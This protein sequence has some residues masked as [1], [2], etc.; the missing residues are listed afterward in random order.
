MSIIK[1]FALPWKIV[2]HSTIKLHYTQL[3]EEV[4]KEEDNSTEIEKT[5]PINI[6]REGEL[7][8][9]GWKI[10]WTICSH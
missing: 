1:I 2:E 9:R 8:V 6:T 7:K 5:I 4:S 3:E 10:D